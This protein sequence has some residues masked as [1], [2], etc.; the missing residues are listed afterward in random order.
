MLPIVYREILKLCK[1]SNFSDLSYLQ[2]LN[3]VF[4]KKKSNQEMDLD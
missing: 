3:I 4:L 1:H 2:A